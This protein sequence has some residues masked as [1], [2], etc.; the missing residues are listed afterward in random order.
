[1]PRLQS[2]KS[3]VWVAPLLLIV[4]VVCGGQAPVPEPVTDQ[5]TELGQEMYN[6]LSSKGE[7]VEVLSPIRDPETDN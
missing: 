2:S 5:E 6:E 4:L 3:R 7:I 1:M